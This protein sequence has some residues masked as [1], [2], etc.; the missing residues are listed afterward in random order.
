MKE[1]E[2]AVD[3]LEEDPKYI[4]PVLVG[5]YVSAGG[6]DVLK[7]FNGFGGLKAKSGNIRKCPD[8][9]STTCKSRTIKQTMEKLFSI[10]GIHLDPQQIE[11]AV[12]LIH[13]ALVQ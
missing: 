7:K 2:L 9:Y 11:A 1:Y 8:E 5:E 3:K 12:D 13:T 6:E 10:Q 4:V